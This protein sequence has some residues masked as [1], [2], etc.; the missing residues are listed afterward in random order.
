MDMLAGFDEATGGPS[1]EFF[2]EPIAIEAFHSLR[3]RGLL[4]SCFAY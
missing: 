3:R 1:R 4:T 2:P